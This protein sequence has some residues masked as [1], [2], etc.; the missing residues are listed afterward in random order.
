MSPAVSRALDPLRF[1]PLLWMALAALGGV[2]LGGQWAQFLQPL[3]RSDFRLGLPFIPALLCLIAALPLRHHGI[4]RRLCIAAFLLFAFAGAAA[5]RVTPPVGDI[6]ELTQLKKVPDGSIETL[7]MK[8]SGVVADYPRIGDFNIQ[9]P[10]ECSAP[11]P[12]RVWISAPYN[13][14][15]RIG[16]RVE[17]LVELRPLPRPGNTGE[18]DTTWRF[19]GANAWC[20]GRRVVVAQRLGVAP[21]Y[22][23]ARRIGNWREGLL[24]HY[25]T[26]FQ[27]AGD[28]KSLRWRPFPG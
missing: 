18:S 1:R 8:I 10:L 16:D 17:L 24:H 3:S 12:G 26:Q 23:L 28:D 25:E 11:S 9:F 19:I 2:A 21:G 6:S 27:G 15:F 22:G 5:R 7:P 13:Q 14:K 20:L 4:V